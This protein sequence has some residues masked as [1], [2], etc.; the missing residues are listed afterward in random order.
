M[1]ETPTGSEQSG[2]EAPQSGQPSQPEATHISPPTETQQ[3]QSQPDNRV[4][5][6]L[7]QVNGMKSIVDPLVQGGFNTPDAVRQMVASHQR[8]AELQSR[9]INIDALV[10]NGQQ[11]KAQ[12]EPKQYATTAEINSLLDSREARS[13]HSQANTQATSSLKAYAQEVGGDQ[14]SAVYGLAHTAAED[15]MKTNGRLYPPSHPLHETDYMPLNETD[16]ANIKS[17]VQKQMDAFRGMNARTDIDGT[18]TPG[19]RN[20]TD[21]T[22]TDPN[23]GTGL[24]DAASRKMRAEE[25]YRRN[26]AALSGESI[27]NA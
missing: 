10:G 16:I 8:L 2:G 9:G 14:A 19:A 1:S 13:A 21:G 7:S 11:Q 6:L 25:L 27:S 24:T 15:Y 4:E 12:E 18:A 20:V 17:T 22:A 3:P 26:L 23:R 5:R